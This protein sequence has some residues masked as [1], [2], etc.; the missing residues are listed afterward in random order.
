MLSPFVFSGPQSFQ[1]AGR[2]F[3][4][5]DYDAAT[6]ADPRLWVLADGRRIKLAM[7]GDVIRMD[8]EV[9]RWGIEP[10]ASSPTLTGVIEI[11]DGDLATGRVHGTVQVIDG[12]LAR[13]WELSQAMA[14]AKRTAAVNFPAL[15]LLCYAAGYAMAVRRIILDTTASQDVHIWTAAVSAEPTYNER[16]PIRNKLASAAGSSFATAIAAAYA[17]TDSTTTGSSDPTCDATKFSNWAYWGPVRVS[18]TTPRL[19]GDGAPIVV[20]AGYA[21]VFVGNTAAGAI[22]MQAEVEGVLA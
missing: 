6:G 3:V 1:A 4:Y 10:Y 15:G 7:P 9:M 21:L 8:R 18:Q 13:V 17:L 19:L 16:R 14:I 22:Q 11:G 12:E 20:E 5:T 2:L